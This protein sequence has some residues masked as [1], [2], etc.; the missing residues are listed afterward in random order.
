M[1]PSRRR[2]FVIASAGILTLSLAFLFVQVSGTPPDF[3]GP[4]AAPFDL[5]GYWTYQDKA[6]SATVQILHNLR[7]NKIEAVFQRG[8]PCAEHEGQRDFYIKG[9]FDPVK[10]ALKG[11]MRLCT[12]NAQL[13][14]DCEDLK[15]WDP[16]YTAAGDTDPSGRTVTRFRGTYKGE[17]YNKDSETG[18]YICDPTPQEGSFILTWVPSVPGGGAPAP[19][20]PLPGEAPAP[21]STSPFQQLWDSV[22]G[23]ANVEEKFWDRKHDGPEGSSD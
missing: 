9:T 21:P 20:G 10:I 17:Y 8:E 6:G 12:T 14:K 16:K 18:K 2:R 19:P 11:T 7:T 3:P 4:P 22:F 15:L 5:N 23:G 13:H 1:K